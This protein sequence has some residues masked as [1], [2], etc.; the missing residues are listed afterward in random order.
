ME[1]IKIM[2]SLIAYTRERALQNRTFTGA[3]IVKHGE[4]IWQ[5]VTSIE[6]DKNP[7]AHAELKALQGVI[8]HHGP[9]LKGCHLYTTQQ[10]C[11]MCASAMVWSGIEKVVYG[12]ASNAHWKTFD[13]TRDFF[14]QFGIECVGPL[15]AD[16]CREIDDYLIANGI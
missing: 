14:A 4:I 10:P 7:L 2:K 5:G 12:L 9:V 6:P 15:L 11:P 16:E 1:D 13:H 8:P 3:Y